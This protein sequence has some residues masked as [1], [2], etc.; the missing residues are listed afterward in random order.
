MQNRYR[1]SEPASDV[2]DSLVNIGPATKWDL[3]DDTGRD[4]K[5]VERVLRKLALRGRIAEAG[6]GPKAAPW[7][8]TPTLWRVA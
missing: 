2:L 3:A 8:P 6:E 1:L 7:G 4:L 5:C